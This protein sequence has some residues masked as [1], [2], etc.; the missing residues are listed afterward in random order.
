M[1]GIVAL[2]PDELL[3]TVADMVRQSCPEL[4]LTRI[5]DLDMK[6]ICEQQPVNFLDQ[7]LN[8]LH[9]V[10]DMFGLIDETK[11]IKKQIGDVEIEYYAADWM[12][13]EKKVW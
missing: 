13:G 9:D 7:L 11:V 4:D 6:H 8:E 1:A 3:Q 2:L 10:C 5:E 12:E